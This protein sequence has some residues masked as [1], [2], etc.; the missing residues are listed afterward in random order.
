M[1]IAL[2]SDIHANLEALNAL[3]DILD[4]ADRIFCL[5]DLVGYYCQVNEVIDRLRLLKALCLLGNHDSFLLGG[6]PPAA[7]PAVQFGI[8][9]AERTIT[10]ANRAW[11]ATLPLIWGGSADGQSF[12][13]THGSPWRPMDD[14]LYADNPRLTQLNAFDFDVVAF[15][16]THRVFQR[17]N[18]KPLLLNPGSVGQSRDH[19]AQACALIVDTCNLSVETVQRPY[20][21]MPVIELALSNGAGKWINKHLRSE[22]ERPLN[23]LKDPRIP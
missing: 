2:I 15:G 5:G 13:L 8:A 10:A 12:L 6:C 11:L 21:P 18:Q 16:Q 7:T 23:I 4:G 20:D 3:G 17:L 1:R 14:Y 9:Q 22:G 19:S